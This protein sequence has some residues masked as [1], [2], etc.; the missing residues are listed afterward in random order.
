MN[1]D[2]LSEA[3]IRTAEMILDVVP[4]G[5]A[6]AEDASQ[7]VETI[8]AVDGL[9]QHP[10][11]NCLLW[12]LVLLRRWTGVFRAA[13]ERSA[14]AAATLEHE[15]D[16]HQSLAAAA[17]HLIGMTKDPDPEV[18]SMIYRLLGSASE[19]ADV[20]ALLRSIAE[21]ESDALAR[22]CAVEA[23]FVAMIRRWPNVAEDDLRW[24]RERALSGEPA[25]RGRI[26]HALDGRALVQSSSVATEIL[27][28]V[29]EQLPPEGPFW[30]VESI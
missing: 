12:I 18:R 23:V 15:A 24:L 1:A 25:V 21:A 5:S 2:S 8:V 7:V 10:Y 11:R 6:P 4:G 20:V 29:L 22:G 26:R 14:I 30:P 13:S 17:D 3:Y 9:S 27:S 19:R 28:P 16:T